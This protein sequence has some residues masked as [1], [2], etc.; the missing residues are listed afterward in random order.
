MFELPVTVAGNPGVA[1]RTGCT[2]SP[3]SVRQLTRPRKCGLVVDAA[4]VH[5]HRVLVG[6]DEPTHDDLEVSVRRETTV[7]EVPDFPGQIIT[8]DSANDVGADEWPIDP[9]H[10]SKGQERARGGGD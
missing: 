8:D 3:T 7:H 9:V 2:V 10:R 5:R 1:T 4:F 6:K